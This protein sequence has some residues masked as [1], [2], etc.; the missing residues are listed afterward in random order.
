MSLLSV[1]PYAQTLGNLETKAAKRIQHFMSNAI[2]F[3]IKEEAQGGG[4]EAD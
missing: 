2:I 3:L 1:S 4:K